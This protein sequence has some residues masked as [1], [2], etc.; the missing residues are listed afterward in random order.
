MPLYCLHD[1]DEAAGEH[2]GYVAGRKADGDLTDMSIDVRVHL[3]GR[4]VAYVPRCECG[5]TGPPFS[6]TPN[7]FAACEQL[8]RV[9]HL[10]PFLRA[11]EPN[12]GRPT[13]SWTPT[14]IHGTLAVESA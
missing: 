11:R 12:Y 8:W 2:E 4:Y 13:V 5:W 10:E 1:A 7:G 3:D 6:T 9:K 14:V